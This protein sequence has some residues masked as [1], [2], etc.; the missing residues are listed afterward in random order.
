MALLC[1]ALLVLEAGTGFLPDVTVSAY[2]TASRLV[3][4]VGLAAVLARDVAQGRS[5]LTPRPPRRALALYACVAA[6]LGW[7][8]LA[9]IAAPATSLPAIRLLIEQALAFGLVVLVI[10][11]VDKLKTLGL[12]VLATVSAISLHALRQ[13][14]TGEITEHALQW[15]GSSVVRVVGYFPNPNVFAAF[16]VLLLPLVVVLVWRAPLPSWLALLLIALPGLALVLTF[17]RA[18]L[19]GLLLA[20]GLVMTRRRSWLPLTVAALAVTAVVNPLSTGRLLPGIASRVEVWVAALGIIADHPLTGVGVGNF[21]AAAPRYWNAHNLY[22]HV[23]AESGVVAGLLLIAVLVLAL[24]QAGELSGRGGDAG[25]V[26]RAFSISI[27][28]FAAL[29]MVD[30]PYNAAAVRTAFWL[31][32]GLLAAALRVT[33]ARERHRPRPATTA[34]PAVAGPVSADDARVRHP[35]A[36][37]P[38]PPPA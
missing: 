36:P 3:L 32:L 23:A 37:L 18:A 29:S 38:Q 22:L 4:L 27:L 6:L 12:V 19:V 9:A 30:A 14:T 31:V 8:V 7:Q 5:P 13:F 2:L 16:L 15:N 10:D 28:A 1:T 20:V 25:A 35:V 11:D 33:P 24:S 21:Q 34:A 26:G 17:S